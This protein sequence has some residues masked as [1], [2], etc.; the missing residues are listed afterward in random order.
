MSFMDLYNHCDIVQSNSFE[1]LGYGYN[2]TYEQLNEINQTVLAT[3]VLPLSDPVLSR[4]MYVSKQLRL[5]LSL[6]TRYTQ[7]AITG[8]DKTHNLKFVTYSTHDWTVA[9]ML[10]FLDADNGAFE[11]LPFASNVKIELHSTDECTKEECFWVEVNY[12]GKDLEFADD[13]ASPARCT[14]PEF[15]TMLQF[16][17]FVNTSTHYEKECAKTWSPNSNAI[18]NFLYRHFGSAAYNIYGEFTSKDEGI[19]QRD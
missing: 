16:K 4:N 6:M 19:E 10:L 3:L 18:Q 13:C 5:P 15:M 9:Q 12:N 17:G 2:Y 7:S 14:Y 11:V 1:G 8:D